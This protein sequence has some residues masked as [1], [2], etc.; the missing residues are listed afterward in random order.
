MIIT[1]LSYH[2]VSYSNRV[3]HG[4]A[5]IACFFSTLSNSGRCSLT[6]T[7]AV[8]VGDLAGV[9]PGNSGLAA[10]ANVTEPGPRRARTGRPQGRSELP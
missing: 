8:T 6:V 3:I 9:R 10:A 1:V 2:H 5:A 4:I 7:P